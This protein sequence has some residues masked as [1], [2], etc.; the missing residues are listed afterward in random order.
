MHQRLVRPDIGA[1]VLNRQRHMN[2]RNLQD[3]DDA[4]HKVQQVPVPL[5]GALRMGLEH[6]PGP[7]QIVLFRFTLIRSLRQRL[8]RF[9]LHRQLRHFRLGGRLRRFRRFRRRSG[10]GR[11]GRR[12]LR[13]YIHHLGFPR[14]FIDPVYLGRHFRGFGRGF[15]GRRRRDL[16]RGAH[17][18]QGCRPGLRRR[19]LFVRLPRLFGGFRLRGGSG[20]LKLRRDA[21]GL[22]RVVEHLRERF[23]LHD[24]NGP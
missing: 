19:P 23:A 18:F 12:R 2:R 5:G 9:G 1:D 3:A 21:V 16:R 10:G 11:R 13:R 22:I 6:V 15:R 7:D 8:H 14:E 17:R 20:F 4:V 24:A